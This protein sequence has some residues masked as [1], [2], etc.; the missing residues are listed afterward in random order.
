MTGERDAQSVLD[1]VA[2]LAQWPV[3]Q[4][5][6][7]LQALFER[8]DPSGRSFDDD[9]RAMLHHVGDTHRINRRI[10][11]NRRAR[12]IQEQQ[13]KPIE[14]RLNSLKY[15]P[16][17]LELD[18]LE[19]AH[20]VLF[21]LQERGLSEQV[22]LPL[23][24]QLLQAAADPA[25]L[26][27]FLQIAT[28]PKERVRK[29]ADVEAFELD[30]LSGYAEWPK[31]AAT[32][33]SAAWKRIDE[34]ALND[35]RRSAEAWQMAAESRPRLSKLIAFLK[36]KQKTESRSKFVVFAGF[37]GLAKQLCVALCGEFTSAAVATSITEWK[38]WRRKSRCAGL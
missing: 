2:E 23:A 33:W 27:A 26:F 16:D 35:A 7:K 12:L 24:R 13:V 18:A 4:Q 19:Y 3:L 34:D 21:G 11:R 37:P 6:Q 36:S 28:H 30:S 17:Q 29:G 38:M 22:L 8:I 25:T 1:K 32:L 15:D 10:L 9:V 20:R 5:D 14:R 31:Y